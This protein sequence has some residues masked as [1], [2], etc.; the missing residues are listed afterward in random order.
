MQAVVLWHVLTHILIPSSFLKENIIHLAHY[1]GNMGWVGLQRP[2]CRYTFMLCLNLQ[3][4]FVL[5][6]SNN[7][8][9]FLRFHAQGDQSGPGLCRYDKQLWVWKDLLPT[10]EP[11]SRAAGVVKRRLWVCCRAEHAQTESGPA[12]WSRLFAGLSLP[13]IQ[14]PHA[15]P[16]PLD[17]IISLNPRQRFT[18]TTDFVCLSK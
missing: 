18:G 7:M 5:H 16:S 2:F 12:W 8:L 4:L 6:K 9:I 3:R 13:Q 10:D 1:E 11:W 17:S 14:P 15:T